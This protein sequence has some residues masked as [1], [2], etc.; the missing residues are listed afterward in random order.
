MLAWSFYW[1][2]DSL[3]WVLL[4]DGDYSE[5][6]EVM[7]AGAGAYKKGM[8][9]EENFDDMVVDEGVIATKVGS[10]FKRTKSLL[11]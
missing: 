8:E 6:D 11:E 3:L 5:D 7:E 9:F 2:R 1:R 10:K 4:I